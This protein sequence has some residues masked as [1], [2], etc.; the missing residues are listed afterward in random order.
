[1]RVLI[2]GGTGFIG[3]H[4]ALELQAHGHDVRLLVRD[5]AKA[6]RLYGAAAPAHV[7][8]DI[9][10][11]TAM[12]RALQGCDGLVH[13]AAMV[14]TDL[15]DADKVYNTNVEGTR[16]AIGQAVALGLEKIVHVSSVTAIFDRR[17]RKLDEH[18]PPGAAK[19]AYGRSKVASEEYVRSL[20]EQGAPIH[21]VYPAT[22]I[23]PDD[24]GLTEPLAGLTGLLHVRAFMPGGSQWVDVRDIALAH[25]KL[26][27]QALPPGR[28]PLGGHF[29][30]WPAL[31]RVLE[32]LTGRRL[33]PLP[34]LGVTAR[35]L[36]RVFD[37]LQ[38]LLNSTLPLSHEAA[39]YAT[40]WV[41]MDN[42]KAERELGLRFRP[43]EESLA[44][45]IRWLYAAGHIN[46]RLAGRLADD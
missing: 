33:P 36:G 22:V 24:P 39:V 12:R 1:M 31:G 8:G 19:D 3:Y 41:E 27:E 29:L 5:P 16:N 26:L 40:Q 44:D 14:S 25:R 42:R 10:D 28:Y 13:T 20:Q 2:T 15:A 17:A 35:S 32:Q 45:S 18:S 9:A 37:A 4:T 34:I 23:G 38:P 46:A 21:I 7:R 6:K 11:T 30:S 43:V